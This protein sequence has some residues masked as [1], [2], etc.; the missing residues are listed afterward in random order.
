M[1]LNRF[2][3]VLVALTLLVGA[4]TAIAQGVPSS[5]LTGRVLNEGLGGTCQRL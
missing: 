5:T 2:L 1:R 4:A 3:N